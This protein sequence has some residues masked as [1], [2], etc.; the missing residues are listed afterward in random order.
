MSNSNNRYFLTFIDDFTHKIWVNFLQRKLEEFDYFKKFKLHVERQSGYPIKMLRID[1]GGEYTSNE[2]RAYCEEQGT[3]HEVTF[4]D[5]PLR[6]GVA[7]RKN[8]TI[9]DMVRSMLKTKSMLNSFWGKVVSCFVYILNWSPTKDVPNRT[10][11][12]A[13]GG[14]KP[15]VK[16][17]NVFG[18]VA[19]SHIPTKTR[20]KLDDQAEKTI[21]IGY[22]RGGY[23]LFNPVSKKV[24][25]SRDVTFAKET[26]WN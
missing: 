3:H 6:N 1:D 12:E 2:F 13:W 19:S 20:T 18:T 10:L 22:K 11:A 14:F 8:K 16:H 24:I 23:K 9:L 5:T 25:V 7:E 15:S 4:P 21:F 26:A 17:L